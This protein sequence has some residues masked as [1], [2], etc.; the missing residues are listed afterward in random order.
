MST[1][2][3]QDWLEHYEL[4]D[5]RVAV[6]DYGRYVEGVEFTKSLFEQEDGS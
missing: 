1:A 5:C 6:E 2:T 3:F 4:P